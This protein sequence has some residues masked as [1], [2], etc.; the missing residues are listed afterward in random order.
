MK[1][2]DVT[3][4]SAPTLA[5]RP[6]PSRPSVRPPMFCD[7]DLTTVPCLSIHVLTFSHHLYQYHSCCIN[8][9]ESYRRILANFDRSKIINFKQKIGRL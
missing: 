5:L 6:Q 1:R 9:N 8:L 4:E 7:T 3:K 2:T